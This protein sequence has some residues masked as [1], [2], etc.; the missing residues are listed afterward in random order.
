VTCGSRYRESL[1]TVR[2]LH[3]P[4]VEAL[5][6][7]PRGAE[8]IA[9][10]LMRIALAILMISNGCFDIF[11]RNPSFISLIRVTICV[12]LSVGIFTPFLGIIA[13]I[14]SAWT[15]FGS[16]LNL[17]FVHI[18]TLILSAA[19]ALLSPGALSVDALLFG[20]RRVIF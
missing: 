11:A 10:L 9:R 12:A 5:Y 15:L 16:G 18:A 6:R 20:R 8:G 19:V 17:H 1:P 13:S 14:L 2:P 7:Y 4:C 3:N